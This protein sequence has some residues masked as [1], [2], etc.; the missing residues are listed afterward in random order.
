MKPLDRL[1][2]RPAVAA[3]AGLAVVF[4]ALLAL[5][6]RIVAGHHDTW[7]FDV[8]AGAPVCAAALLRRRSRAWA[9]AAGLALS[10]AAEFAAWRWD[11]ARQPGAAMIL[12]LFVLVASAA[13]VL[14]AR[15]VAAVTAG[16][17]VVAAGSIE[18][19][20][21]FIESGRPCSF[22]ATWLMGEG[23]AAAL[24]AG[25]WLRLLD[26]RRRAA[27]A[28]V[29]HSERLNLAREL[30]DTAAHHITGIVLQAQAARIAARRHPE[31]LD[32]ALA[33]I[34]SA[35]TEALVSLRRVVGLLRD[36][37]DAGGPARAPERLDDLVRRFAGRGTAV[38]LRLP[39]GGPDWPPEVTTTVYRVVQEALTNIARH[40]SGAR[41]V[42]V[43]VT[44]DGPDVSV[45]VTDDAPRAGAFPYGGGYGL[46]G[47]RER[48]EAL[49]GTLE[50]GPG[51]AA[52]WS[53][54]AR[55]PVPAA[56]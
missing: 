55:L 37:D 51:A 11:L 23:T 28:A 16:T 34:E 25:L 42:A 44:R 9:A 52:G 26:G 18:R 5:E 33:G 24:G 14:P 22:A 7:V 27:F 31:R 32:E 47:M 4:A 53:V 41:E 17:A 12:A 35:G 20:I 38:R 21:P 6:A 46:A 36:D 13:R 2:E 39:E 40:A 54:R 15:V 1:A 43:T 3:D 45:E 8:A 10:L 56:P 50:A 29:R 48:V 19:Y 30:H 49:G